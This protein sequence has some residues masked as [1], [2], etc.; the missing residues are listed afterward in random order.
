MRFLTI[1]FLACLFIASSAAAQCL[2]P[3]GEAGTQIYNST[4]NVMQYCN[5]S[6]WIGMGWGNGGMLP[7]CAVGQGIVMGADGWNCA[8]IGPDTTPSAFNFNDVTG[9]AASTLTTPTPASI[10]I[11]GIDAATPVSVSGDG[12][13]QISIAGG[14]WVT[15]GTITNGQSLAVRL[16]S[17][18][19]SSSR[20]ATID[21]GGVTDT[22]TVATV[23]ADTTPNTFSFNDVTG[24]PPNTLTTPTPA[25]ISIAGINVATPVSVSGQ[26]SPQISIDGGAWVASGTIVNGQTLAVRLTS[27]STGSTT[28]TASIDVGGV[29]DSWSVTTVAAPTCGGAE[30]GGYCWYYGAMGQSCA[31]ACAS[32]SLTCDETATRNYAGSAGTNANCQA[33]LDALGA[34]A[35]ASMGS[36]PV[37]LGCYYGTSMTGRTRGSSTTTCASSTGTT[38]RACV[39]N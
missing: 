9:A 23:G 33:V 16:T 35:D 19:P 6:T 21:I 38:N 36:T 24:A 28:R 2:N 37:A 8:D 18:G 5:G 22:W 10:T 32:V 25:S 31:V 7:A 1:I 29:T 13:P 39:C 15:S 30:V 34:P 11:G 4:H 3:S 26:G 17:G 20:S 27:A 12:S 14:P